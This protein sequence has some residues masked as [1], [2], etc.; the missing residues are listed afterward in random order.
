MAKRRGG[1]GSPGIEIEA[2]GWHLL[3]VN[4]HL[5][6]PRAHP[7]L[8]RLPAPCRV[9]AAAV[10]GYAATLVS[11]TQNP[12]PPPHTHIQGG[13]GGGEGL[14]QDLGW[15]FFKFLVNK[16]GMPVTLMDQV[17]KV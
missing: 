2:V 5:P 12:S 15:N 6:P 13:G 9:A 16:Q 10:R 4:H 8:M 17:R 7:P 11:T 3:C 14:G 1:E